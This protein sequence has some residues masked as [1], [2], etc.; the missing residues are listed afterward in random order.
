MQR[1]LLSFIL[2]IVGG[3]VWAQI[4]VKIEAPTVVTVGQSFCIDYTVNDG[5]GEDFSKPQDFPGMKMTYFVNTFTETKEDINGEASYQSSKNYFRY[6]VKAEKEGTFTIPAATVRVKGKTY[7]FDSTSIKVLPADTCGT[8]STDL[9]KPTDKMDQVDAENSFVK[10]VV[11][12]TKIHEQEAFIVTFKVYSIYRI[13]QVVSPEF[14]EFEDFI[15]EDIPIPSNIIMGLEQYNER[16][17]YTADFKKFLL[18]PQRSGK[19][20]IPPAKVDI[21]V[22]APSGR[23][24]QTPFGSENLIMSV[25]TQITTNPVTIDASTLPEGKIKT[26]N[27]IRASE[28]NNEPT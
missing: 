12:K 2:L 14:P 16:N 15:I 28:N 19:L 18:F 17:Y 27:N 22:E 7:T 6:T 10:A 9:N 24:V 26:G 23:I 8:D 13:R 4:N 3:N 21:V 11:S 1:I 20:T 5:K 25:S